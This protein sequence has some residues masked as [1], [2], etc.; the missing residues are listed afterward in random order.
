MVCTFGFLTV[1]FLPAVGLDVGAAIVH[2]Q[3]YGLCDIFVEVH[4][5][6]K[7]WL[8]SVYGDCQTLN[9]AESFV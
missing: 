9:G 8:C 2:V 4:S 3:K 6:T 1:A 5:S 7:I